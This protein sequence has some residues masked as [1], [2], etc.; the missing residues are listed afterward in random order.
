MVSGNQGEKGGES[1]VGGGKRASS[2]FKSSE[3][4]YR[5]SSCRGSSLRGIE[6][7]E[8]ETRMSL[9]SVKNVGDL[10][11]AESGKAVARSHSSVK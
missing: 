9:V 1:D 10:G 6:N 2:G 11:A 4:V 8:N 7:S 3:M 5:S